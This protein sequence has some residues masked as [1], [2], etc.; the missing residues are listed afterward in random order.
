ML[1]RE[2][3][4]RSTNEKNFNTVDLDW[5]KCIEICADGA[6]AMSGRNSS[7]LTKILERNPNAL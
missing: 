2:P 5:R 6:H 7:V 4:S 3:V 1:L